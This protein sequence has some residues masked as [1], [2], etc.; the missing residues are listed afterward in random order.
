MLIFFWVNEGGAPPPAPATT[1]VHGGMIGNAGRL[2]TRL[3]LIAAM[4][5]IV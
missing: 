2:M 5:G 4:T 1:G 3:L